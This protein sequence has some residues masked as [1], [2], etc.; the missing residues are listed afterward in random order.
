MT[1]AVQIALIAAVPGSLAAC[2]GIINL[3]KIGR[4]QEHVDG[5]LS[6][7]KSDL[8]DANQA[9]LLLTQSAS[10]KQEDAAEARGHLQGVKDELERESRPP[11]AL[12]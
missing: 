5:D 3:F 2:I 6:T 10:L 4:V 7:V 1:E 12:S 8:K 11:A 9:L